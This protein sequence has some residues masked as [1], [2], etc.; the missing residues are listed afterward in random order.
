MLEEVT[1]TCPACWEEIVLDIDLS[2]GDQ[3]V[4]SEDCPVCCRPMTV[5]VEVSSDSR[6]C[7]VRIEPESD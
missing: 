5:H 4:Y 1:V 7:R 2:G 6:S 3:Q